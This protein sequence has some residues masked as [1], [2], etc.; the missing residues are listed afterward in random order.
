M[1]STF[2]PNK[3]LELPGFNDYVNS[4]NTPVNSDMTIIDTAL[5]GSTLLNAT[6][7]TGN[8]TLTYTQYRPLSLIVSGAMSADVSYIVP[9]GVGGQWTVSNGTSGAFSVYMVSAAGGSSIKIPQGYSTIVSCDGTSSGMRF[10]VSTALAAGGN[11]RVQYN[12]N[13]L[14]AGAAN[15]TFDGT[16]LSAPA[17]AGTGDITT[18][19]N[20]LRV[21]SGA[22]TNINI[23]QWNSARSINYYLNTDG[24]AGLIDNSGGGVRYYTDTNGNFYV[25]S[26]QT[27]QIGNGQN[28]SKNLVYHNSSRV[29]T[30]YLDNSSLFGL[31]DNSGGFVRWYSSNNGDF[32]VYGTLYQGFSDARLKA[33]IAPISDALAKVS[34][35]N[36]VTFNANE[37]AGSFGYKDTKTQ[38]GV[39]AHEIEAVLPEAVAIAPFDTDHKDGVVTSKSG[40]NY[41]TV[42]YEKLVPLLIEAIKELAAKVEALEARG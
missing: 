37:L 17:F 28:N 10:S 23:Q 3:T 34:R 25:P 41:K 12:S 42:Q 29:V 7:P 20:F 40:K 16:T 14:F 26:G 1:A 32:N 27:L 18:N 21:G 39:L 22:N 11:T 35:I 2:S 13:G 9:A 5:G 30:L 38:A 15:F 24:T 36:G 31:L 8:V 19:G 6:S 33:N 4:W